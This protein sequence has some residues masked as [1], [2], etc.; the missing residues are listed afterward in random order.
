MASAS[1]SDQVGYRVPAQFSVAEILAMMTVFG[2]LFGGL[3]YFGAPVWLYPFLGS[4]GMAICLVQM[5]FGNVPRGAS[6]LVGC[7]FLPG[8]MAAVAIFAPSQFAMPLSH[9]VKELPFTV[10][11]GGLVGYCTGTMAAG[12]FLVLDKLEAAQRAGVHVPRA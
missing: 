7:V 3:R 6:T 12:V 1:K 8:W 4:Q 9:V 11:F 5:R 2:L 10:P